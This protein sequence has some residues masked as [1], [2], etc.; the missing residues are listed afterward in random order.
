MP[1]LATYTHPTYSQPLSKNTSAPAAED[2]SIQRM[3][4][5]CWRTLVEKG[6]PSGDARELAIAIVNFI[7]VDNHL[8]HHQKYLV[9]R[10]YRHLSTLE[11]SLLQN[12]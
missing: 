3:G 7:Y 4:T 6:V 12:C 10:Y 1:A 11:L 9:G 5:R 2:Q 8:S